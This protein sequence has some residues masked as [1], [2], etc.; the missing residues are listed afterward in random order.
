M[1]K[2]SKVFALNANQGSGDKARHNYI[3]I[4]DTANDNNKGKDSAKNEASY[5]KRNINGQYPAYTHMIV[6][7]VAAYEVGEPGYVA[8]G[9]GNANYDSP[10]QIELAHVDTQARFNKSYANF[11]ELIRKYAKIY[12]I[13]LTFDKGKAGNRGVKSHYWVSKNIW[14]DHT[15]PFKYLE[16]WGISKKQ[17]AHDIKYGI[18]KKT[19]K[20]ATYLNSSNEFKVKA[21]YINVYADIAFKQ[22]HGKKFAKGSVITGNIVKYGSITRIKTNCG[23]VSSNTKFTTKIK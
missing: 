9:A 5:M 22:S 14:G 4:H 15:D 1:V 23:Y 10:F 12:S 3:I 7:D 20:K 6:N 8:W 11:I 19:A 17:L 21:K 16:K 18:G 13:P 2:V